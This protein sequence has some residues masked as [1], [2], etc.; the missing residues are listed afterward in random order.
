MG[1]GLIF[2]RNIFY[3]KMDWWWLHGGPPHDIPWLSKETPMWGR[4]QSH[5][6]LGGELPT[7]RLGGLVLTPVMFVDIAPTKIP[8]I[9]RVSSPTYD[10]WDEQPS[11]QS[12]ASWSISGTPWFLVSPWGHTY[13]TYGPM[14][15]CATQV[16]F[17]GVPTY[18]EVDRFWKVCE[19]YKADAQCGGGAYLVE[20]TWGN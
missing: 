17:E 1:D 14:L 9:T 20:R 11:S 6:L 4:F 3:S 19:K 15:N 12:L 18:P 2:L 5:A 16:L 13:V 7:N 8:F 10:S